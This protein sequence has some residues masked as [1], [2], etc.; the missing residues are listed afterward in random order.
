MKPFH[1]NKWCCNLCWKGRDPAQSFVLKFILQ[2]N[3]LTERF[4]WSVAQTHLKSI[5]VCA[6]SRPKMLTKAYNKEVYQAS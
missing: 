4:Y 3:I 5:V 1:G 6:R 2:L